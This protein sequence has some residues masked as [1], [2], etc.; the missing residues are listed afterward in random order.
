MEWPFAFSRGPTVAPLA[1]AR[2]APE[3]PLKRG[4]E[5]GPETERTG[6]NVC[7]RR[8]GSGEVNGG[9]AIPR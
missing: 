6:E 4:D 9:I 3:D 8:G 2:G 7:P 1:G 5:A